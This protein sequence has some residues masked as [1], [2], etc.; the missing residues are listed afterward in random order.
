MNLSTL[1]GV[2]KVE[3]LPRFVPPQAATLVE[4]AP[5]GEDW[6]H[7]I[8]FDG[9]RA[10]ARIDSGSAEIRSRNDKDWTQAYAMLA[11]EMS[12]LPVENAILDGEV[13]VQLPDGTTSFEALRRVP[14]EAAGPD[15]SGKSGDAGPS[16]DATGRL[17]Y[18]AFDLLYLNSYALLDVPIEQ[19]RRLLR[20]VLAQEG[21]SGRILFSEHIPGDGPSLL[22]KACALRLEGVVSKR[23]STPY[24][25]GVRGSDWVKTKCHRE[26]EFVIGGYTDPSGTRTGF[27]ALLLGVYHDGRLRYVSKVG[28]GFDER[29]LLRL[30][31]RLREMEVKDPPFDENL[32]RNRAGFH[33]VRPE[34]VAQVEFLEWT[35]AG[36]IRHPS[37]KGLREDKPAREVT[38]ETPPK[39][40]GRRPARG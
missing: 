31:A 5:D 10:L 14:R 33:W 23:A 32:P 21:E 11:A 15:V 12:G 18:Y 13:V 2:R 29:L 38:A 27:G 17:L 25:P 19:R 8:K 1:K 20:E 36:G 9:Y 3:E 7:E 4:R 30:G 35:A 24:R 40:R 26:Q 39:T 22:A 37:F 28:T 34:L 16:R 6:L